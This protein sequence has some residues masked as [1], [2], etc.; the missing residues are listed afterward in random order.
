MSKVYI[1]DILDKFVSKY[2]LI[3]LLELCLSVVY[4]SLL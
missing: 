4:P 2:W 3:F 1:K